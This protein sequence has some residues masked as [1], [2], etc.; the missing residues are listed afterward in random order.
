M[1][2]CSPHKNGMPN[3]VNVVI[4]LLLDFTSCILFKT[5]MGETLWN[6]LSSLGRWLW[7]ATFLLL[8]SL[9]SAVTCVPTL[10]KLFAVL[11]TIIGWRREIK[12]LGRVWI[13]SWWRIRG[14]KAKVKVKV[15]VKIRSNKER[16]LKFMSLV[17]ISFIFSRV[18]PCTNPS[19]KCSL[20]GHNGCGELLDMRCNF[21]FNSEVF[22][23]VDNSVAW[24]CPSKVA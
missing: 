3:L 14:R 23:K 11:A 6:L 21:K 7:Y 1:L 19:P 15:K 2:C 24:I 9:T 5:V 10:R 20:R 12:A 13:M 18:N 17:P 8:H 4:I 16:K 22:L